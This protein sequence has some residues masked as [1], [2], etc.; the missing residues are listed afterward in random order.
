[1]AV[2]DAGQQFDQHEPLFGPE[3]GQN[4]ILG[5]DRSRLKSPAQCDAFWGQKQR[6]HTS[7]GRMP[8]ADGE[9]IPFE[10]VNEL[11]GTHLIDAKECGEAPLLDAGLAV[12]DGECAVTHSS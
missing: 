6:A 9:I 12:Q 7:I 2:D 11:A 10:P 8:P 1:M 3:R 4:A 5:S